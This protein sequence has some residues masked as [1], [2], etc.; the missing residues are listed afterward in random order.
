MKWYKVNEKMPP[1]H[2]PVFVEVGN[3]YQIMTWREE[4]HDWENKL[5]GWL[6]GHVDVAVKRWA[7]L[8]MEM[9]GKFKSCPYYACTAGG[10]RCMGTNEIDACSCRGMKI[11]CDFYEDIREDGWV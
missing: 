5:F 4:D 6:S 9:Y 11:L 2:I 1:A 10:G 3:S 8:P 7:Y